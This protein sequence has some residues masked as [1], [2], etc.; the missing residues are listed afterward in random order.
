MNILIIDDDKLTLKAVKFA[1]VKKGYQVL[2]ASNKLNALNKLK[3]NAVDCIVS[4][5]NLPDTAIIDLVSTLKQLYKHI[6]IVLISSEAGN[7]HI[8]DS[9]II[10]ADA[11]VPK[12]VDFNLLCDVV[13]RLTPVNAA[14]QDHPSV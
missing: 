7:P 1:L 5:V 6:P 12:P 14:D 13:A 2:I 8:D 11:F 9:L 4:D 10:G 3:S